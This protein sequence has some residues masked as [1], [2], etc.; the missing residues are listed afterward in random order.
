M[1]TNDVL[2]IVSILEVSYPQHY[3][4]LTQEQL[5]NQ[6]MLW[7]ELWKDTDANLIANTVKSMING[8]INPFPPTIGQIN[9]RA[10]EL[11]NKNKRTVQE[12]V[13]IVQRVLCD[14]GYYAKRE[15]ESLPE[16]VKPHITPNT[17]REWANITN[18]T[19]LSVE[20][21]SWAKSFL[22]RSKIDKEHNMLPNSVKLAIGGIVENMKLENKGNDDE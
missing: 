1:N 12:L 22:E 3:T 17:L 14:C 13:N 15:W 9:Q 4:K 8:D 18:Q 7:S 5:Q 11:T 10:Y 21:N 20:M 19:T 6:I 16:D 2:K